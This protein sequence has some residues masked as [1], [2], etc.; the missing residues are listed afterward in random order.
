MFMQ[1]GPHR[2]RAV[3]FG[4]GGVPLVAHG[5]WTGNWELWEQP[6]ASLSRSRRCISYD[7]LGSGES[8]LPPSVVPD[9][10]T[11]VQSLRD[12]LDTLGVNRCILA[13]ESSGSKVVLQFAVRY[14]ERVQG[15]ILVD[16][17]ANGMSDAALEATLQ[18]L[19]SDY[20]GYLRS[21]IQACLP[22]PEDEHL[23][24][25]GLGILRRASLDDAAALMELSALEATHLPS[26]V[27]V[28]TLVIHGE[29]D[30]IIPPA[31]GQ[32]LAKGISG[33]RLVTVPGAGHVPT[34]CHPEAVVSAIE[35][36][37]QGLS[38]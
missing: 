15:L 8:P 23:R 13:G 19:R 4:T 5:G 22:R 34:M 2:I 1:A 3:S 30:R 25:W 37:V 16:G 28:P 9:L 27:R 26:Q 29:D 14:P 32:A 36:F 20:D 33:A 6:F 38:G 18:R 11:L 17:F 21:F 7:H 12:V 35:D 10:D 24:R 31:A